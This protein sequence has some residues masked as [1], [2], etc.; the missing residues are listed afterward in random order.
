MKILAFAASNS[1]KSINKELV[2]HAAT[3]LKT[4]IHPKADIEII[5]LNDF[6]MPLFGVDREAAGGIPQQA[7]NFLDKIA[8][9]DALLI[10]F[11][12]HNGSYTVAYKNIFDWTSRID[13]KVY[14]GK[15]AIVL[16]ASPGGRGGASV[17]ETVLN[18]A[19]H[20]GL[21]VKGHL[22]IGRFYDVFKDGALLD[23]ELSSALKDTL[24]SLAA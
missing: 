21:D 2:T 14:Q 5:D 20:Q 9:A 4:E 15:P 10:S 1:T 12:E 24:K 23:A 8:A 11:A 22:S 7:Q 19:P 17:M 13:P 3:I 18:V 16:S 6:E